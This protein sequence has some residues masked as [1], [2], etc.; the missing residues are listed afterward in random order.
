MTKLDLI[1][2]IKA[3]KI[4][5]ISQIE[6]DFLLDDEILDLFFLKNLKQEEIEKYKDENYDEDDND[7]FKKLKCLVYEDVVDNRGDLKTTD[8]YLR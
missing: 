5:K 4:K 2:K 3:G 6:R 8:E 1:E 7:T